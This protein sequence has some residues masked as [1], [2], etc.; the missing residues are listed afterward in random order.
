MKQKAKLVSRLSWVAVAFVI[1]F[2]AV[3][4]GKKA[5]WAAQE[6]PRDAIQEAAA[7]A[8]SNSAV[9]L[10]NP[11][12]PMTV[13]QGEEIL[14]EL[15]AI[16]ILL[17]DTAEVGVR[18]RRSPVPRN[19]KMQVQ[20]GWYEQGRADAPVTMVEFTDLQC[21][22]CRRFQTTTFAEI[23]KDYVD[24]GK[25]RFIALS[26]PLPMHLYAAGAA[27]AS[28]CAGAQGKFWQFRDAV[29]ADRVPPTSIVLLKH[30]KELGLNLRKFQT[31]WKDD[32]YGKVIQA[33]K[34]EAAAVGIHGTPGF[35]VG[36]L[37]GGWIEGV[38]FTGARPFPFF[39]RKIEK[40]LDEPVSPLAG[41]SLPDNSGLR[42]KLC[43]SASV[44]AR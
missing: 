19:V 34:N 4:L 38:A 11:N 13:R 6:R 42:P 8:P 15:R 9:K 43:K 1:T 3:G 14:R 7:T 30:A 26:M 40:E 37:E 17:Q 10:P 16:R 35:V 32:R 18:A 41:T 2:A 29:L 22:F 21:P 36:R 20:P 5:S 28:L 27:E 33:E 24:T 31:C 12:A 23:E 25:L 39:E 44:R